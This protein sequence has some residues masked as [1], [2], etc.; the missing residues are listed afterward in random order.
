MIIIIAQILNPF[1]GNKKVN[2]KIVRICTN[3]LDSP[4][5]CQHRTLFNSQLR[6]GVDLEG[7]LYISFELLLTTTIKL[8]TLKN[9]GHIEVV[10]F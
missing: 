1:W 7:H 6:G 10:F 2:S 4:R 9:I 3:F 8:S 5:L